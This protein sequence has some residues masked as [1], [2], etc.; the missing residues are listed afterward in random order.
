MI[1]E[2]IIK[3]PLELV[4]LDQ[5]LYLIQEFSNVVLSKLDKPR[6]Q[7]L[8]EIGVILVLTLKLEAVRRGRITIKDVEGDVALE[9][10]FIKPKH[11]MM[12]EEVSKSVLTVMGE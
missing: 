9:S 2:Q 8:H 6:E 7:R 11:V 10:I 3:N 4:L 12:T 1:S 5:I